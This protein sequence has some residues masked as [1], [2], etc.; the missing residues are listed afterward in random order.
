MRRR[1]SC[2]SVALHI[3]DDESGV[4]R[5][6]C[7]RTLRARCYFLLLHIYSSR[8]LLS[9]VPTSYIAHI[10]IFTNTECLDSGLDYTYSRGMRWSWGLLYGSAEYCTRVLFGEPSRGWNG[11]GPSQQYLCASSGNG[12]VYVYI[13]MVHRWK[14]E[15]TAPH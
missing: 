6:L 7:Q 8:A 11:M 12:C 14:L 2:L 5:S 9:S 1:G 15:A 3:T 10:H 4:S 13:Y